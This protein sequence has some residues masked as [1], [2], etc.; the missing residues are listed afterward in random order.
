[1]TLLNFVYALKYGSN[2]I[3]LE[4]LHKLWIFYHNHPN[5]IILKKE[6]STL[7]VANRHKNLFILETSSRVILVKR[8]G[9]PTYFLS[10]NL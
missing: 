10:F 8:K 9:W 7:G 6:C 5:F 4:Q 1:M 3:S 2:L